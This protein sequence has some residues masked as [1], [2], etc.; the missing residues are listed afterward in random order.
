[1]IAGREQLE[2]DFSRAGGSVS[3]IP[4]DFLKE[5]FSQV[6][7][8]DMGYGEEVKKEIFMKSL[9][10]GI[11][12]RKEEFALTAG[13]YDPVSK[14]LPSLGKI[15][16]MRPSPVSFG[17]DSYGFS[18]VNEVEKH[19]ADGLSLGALVVRPDSI[20]PTG[21]AVSSD[22]RGLLADL[23][24]KKGFY[25]LEDGSGRHLSFSDGALAPIKALDEN[26]LVIHFSDFSDTFIPDIGLGAV[27][28]DERIAK[29]IEAISRPSS[30]GKLACER[31]LSAGG[32]ENF[33][34]KTL[35]I[36]KKRSEL[37]AEV[38]ESDF[39]RGSLF[40]VPKGGLYISI[41]IPDA[42][43]ALFLARK[44]GIGFVPGEFFHPEKPELGKDCGAFNVGALP[45]ETVVKGLRFLSSVEGVFPVQ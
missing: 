34:K 26:G 17:P 41:R 12:A 3:H 4:L 31:W 29:H 6:E 45:D 23:S 40:S 35:P 10:A 5:A 9:G 37:A 20:V 2:F 27:Y 8:K 18:S 11:R 21:Q 24:K 44:E 1:M 33:R 28:A 13:L 43:K 14:I 42:R 32:L 38:V 19:F 30:L 7:P 22:D 25:I 16:V 15:G 36:Y 39:P